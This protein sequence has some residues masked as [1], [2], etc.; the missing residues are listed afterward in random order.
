MG[1]IN[2][3]FVVLLALT[4]TGV[5]AQNSFSDSLSYYPLQTGNVWEY[6]YK[7]VDALQRNTAYYFTISSLKDTT[8]EN[9]YLY[10]MLRQSYVPDTGKVT[11]WFERVDSATADI[12]RYYQHKVDGRWQT[13]NGADNALI[14]RKE[15]LIDSLNSKSGDFST[16]SRRCYKCAVKTYCN[17]TTNDMLFGNTRQIK[18]FEGYSGLP[19]T[20][21]LAYGIGLTEYDASEGGSVTWELSYAKVNGTEYGTYIDTPLDQDSQRPTEVSLDQ[22]YPNPFNPTTE[23]RYTLDKPGRVKL[24]VYDEIGRLTAI[25]VDGKESA[26]SHTVTFNASQLPSGLYFYKL[27]TGSKILV[28]KMILIK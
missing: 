21:T 4:S 18:R 5:M 11:L 12:Y 17:G 1:K 27:H 25:L 13:E 23:I 16:A 10:H 24:N 8:L 20:Y 26:G 7:A 6:H 19:Y 22:N 28:K 3:V 14:Q 15:Y 2:S 9:G